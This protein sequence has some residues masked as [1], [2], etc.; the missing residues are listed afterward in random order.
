MFSRIGSILMS[1]RNTSQ[2]FLWS[3]IG[4]A[5][6]SST[7]DQGDPLDKNFDRDD[8]A[9]ATKRQF[10]KDCILFQEKA[11][12]LI[13][14][15]DH[16]LAQIAHDFW[17]TRNGHGAGFWDGDYPEPQGTALTKLS[18]S[19]GPVDLYIGDDGKIYAN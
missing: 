4:T 8:L 13:S 16:D 5:L 6:W 11:E 10:E 15:L 17:L 3:Y 9:P 14:S 19:F 18:E 2:A 1:G 12:T 7:D